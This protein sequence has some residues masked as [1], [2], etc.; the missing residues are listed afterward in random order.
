[1]TDPQRYQAIY[2]AALPPGPRAIRNALPPLLDA[3]HFYLPAGAREAPQLSLPQLYIA[4]VECGNEEAR[5]ELKR[6]VAAFEADF[7]WLGALRDRVE[8]DR[9]ALAEQLAVARREVL[10]YQAHT[11]SL[12]G[13]LNEARGRVNVLE[14]ST[15]WRLT[16]PVRRG[17]HRA[18]IE[19][20]RLR[21]TLAALRQTPRYASLALTILRND[22]GS[23]LARRAVQRIGRGKRYVP[24]SGNL[25]RQETAVQPI[26]FTPCIEPRVSIVIPAYGNALLTYTCLKSV[27]ATAPAGLYEVLVIDDASPTPLAPELAVVSGMRIVRNEKNLGFIQSCNQALTQAKGEILVF[28]NND[29][30]VTAG[31]LEALLAVFQGRPDAG[32]VG[33]K[34]IYPD[35]RLQEAGGIVWR[36]GSAW[37][38]GRDDDP[39]KPDYNYLREVDYCSGA[40]LAISRALF[41]RLGGFDVRYAPA[42]Y[43]DADLA[44]SVRASGRKVYYQPLAKIVH[45]EGATSGTDPSAGVK[46]HQVIN[47]AAFANKWATELA[48]HRPNGMAPELERDRR[49]RQRIL[50]VDACMLTPD[51]DAGSMRMEQILGILVDLNCKVTFV[52]DNLE[53]RQP[54]VTALQQLGV[55]VQFAP[56]VR[57][58]P[59]FL[60]TR[61][62]E[63]DVVMLSRHYIAVKYIDTLR[64]FAPRAL[65]VFDTVD[66]HF[67]REERLADLHASPIARNAAIAKRD[68]ELILIRK[69]DLTLVVSTFEQEL[70]GK[71]APDSRVMVLSTIHEPVAGGKSFAEREGLVF[72]GGF[73][74]PPNTDAVLWYGVEVMPRIRE[75]LPGVK[76][77]IIGSDPPPTIRALAAQDFVIA[78]FVPDVTPY[79]TGCRISVSPLRYGAGVKGK[80]NLAMSHGLPVVATTP[81][82]EGM[83][84]TPEVDVLVADDPEAFADAVAR[85]YCDKMIWSRLAE[86]GRENVRTH[87]SRELARATLTRVLALSRAIA[88]SAAAA[89]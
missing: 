72:I 39:D 49:A 9:D 6:R 27:H 12:E 58:I 22:G 11:G 84:L 88:R 73:R 14:T 37:N 81:S 61:G 7:E 83:H 64:S 69:A 67:L 3:K 70:L 10:A 23:A 62:G 8:D 18:K 28:L 82:I 43:E 78:G 59:Q 89:S 57:S 4:G 85:A 35:G 48:N 65:I 53:Y 77:Y 79:F 21:A 31:W 87:F 2:L 71:L 42:Y 68:E 24:A 56:Y 63:F 30:I 50:V 51:Q 26:A 36:D 76:T 52:A 19:L 1:M 34:L 25:Y 66:L 80:V 54:Y 5:L 15:A 74:H 44:F 40:C 41:R 20:S 29:T 13:A 75:R 33:A 55:E 38:Y 46:R 32:L 47:Q 16:A 86:A 17:A 60:G 45:F